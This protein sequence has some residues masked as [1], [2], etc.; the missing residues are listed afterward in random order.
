MSCMP[1]W[2]GSLKL[3]GLS[4]L[5][6]EL[7]QT[8]L[9][10]FPGSGISKLTIPDDANS[11]PVAA[12]AKQFDAMLRLQLQGF[13]LNRGLLIDGRPEHVRVL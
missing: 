4:R 10:L 6:K 8:F 2:G 5:C 11:F 3:G 1:I 7:H 9:V 13:G 12:V